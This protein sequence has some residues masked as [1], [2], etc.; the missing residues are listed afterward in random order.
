MSLE[1]QL[2]SEFTRCEVNPKNQLSII[3]LL[4]SLKHRDLATYEHSI[5]VGLLCTRI[6]R[7][8]FLNPKALL[9]AGCLHDIGKIRIDRELLAKTEKFDERDIEKMR[10]HVEYTH[11][12]LEVFGFHFSAAVGIRHHRHQEKGYPFE[13]P[14]VS[15]NF[16]NETSAL[17]DFYSMLVA[18][19]D[20]YDAATNRV[21]SWSG[22]Q[23][24]LTPEEAKSVLIGCFPKLGFLVE[25]MYIKKVFGSQL[26][27]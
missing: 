20:S 21:N 8:F 25:E 18:L 1:E 24:Q 15:I 5:R 17:I 4:E 10:K 27:R 26:S 14:D 7:Y 2:E 22:R 19:A 6:A 12:I 23:R 9:F 13:L 11:Q 3:A 16:S